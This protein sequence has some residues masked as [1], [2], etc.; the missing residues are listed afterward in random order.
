MIKKVLSLIL[1]FGIFCLMWVLIMWGYTRLDDR[2]YEE[3]EPDATVEAVYVSESTYYTTEPPQK[4]LEIN[5]DAVTQHWLYDLCTSKNVNFY[6]MIALIEKESGFN[7]DASNYDG[8]CIG[9]MQINPD[10]YSIGNCDMFAPCI[11][12]YSGVSHFADLLAFSGDVRWSLDAYHGGGAYA[13]NLKS[14]GIISDYSQSIIER[15]ME[16]EYGCY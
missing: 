13:D 2:N 1:W 10:Y 3:A 9:Y 6:L 7:P 5:M 8:S 11:N 4:I 15:G 14:Q 16:Y 12:L